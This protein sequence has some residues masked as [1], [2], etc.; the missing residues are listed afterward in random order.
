[1]FVR[2]ISLFLTSRSEIDAIAAWF[3]SSW[4]ACA[5]LVPASRTRAMI[6]SVAR[7]IGPL[8]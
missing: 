7:L 5:P 8:E 1:M 2:K 3:D 4:S 6:E